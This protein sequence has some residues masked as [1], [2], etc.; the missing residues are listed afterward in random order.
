LGS[1]ADR[2][3]R[4]QAADRTART[5]VIEIRSRWMV[6]TTGRPSLLPSG[7]SLTPGQSP[8]RLF[9]QSDRRTIN[10]PT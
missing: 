2:A 4:P 9:N 8:D 6:N 3:T 7:T 5:P 10:R 1:A